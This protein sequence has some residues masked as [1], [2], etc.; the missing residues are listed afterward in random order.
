MTR[1]VRHVRFAASFMRKPRESMHPAWL[2]QVAA[3][4][5][6]TRRT[7]PRPGSLISDAVPC[8]ALAIA[9]PHVRMPTKGMSSLVPPAADWET[10]D[11]PATA[12]ATAPASLVAE[13][14]DDTVAAGVNVILGICRPAA[15]A[16]ELAQE[17]SAL[18][19]FASE[20]ARF[21]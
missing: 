6:D 10:A 8:C 1:C 19:R 14:W 18:P 15:V 5:G 21:P 7:Q 4:G 11:A 17:L 3:R 12:E 20:Q 2:P 9:A 16:A 13:M